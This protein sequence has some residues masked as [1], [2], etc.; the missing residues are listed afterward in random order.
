LQLKGNV[1]LYGLKLTGQLPVGVK[2]FITNKLDDA[3]VT[4]GNQLFCVAVGP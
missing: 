1:S 3:S 4:T 2:S